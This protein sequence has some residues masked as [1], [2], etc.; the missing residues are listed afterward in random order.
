MRAIVD[1]AWQAVISQVGGLLPAGGARHRGA[2]PFVIPTQQAIAEK[3]K[4]PALQK[5]AAS[6]AS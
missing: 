6:K 2:V 1:T 3:R 4:E 5:P